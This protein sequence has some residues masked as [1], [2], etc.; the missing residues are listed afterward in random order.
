LGAQGAQYV[1]IASTGVLVSG[2]G[3][4]IV[5]ADCVILDGANSVLINNGTMLA[6]GSAVQVI[7]VDGGTTSITNTGLMSA[8]SY[9][10]WNRFGAGTLN[11]TNTGTVESE[12]QSYFG[13]NAADNVTNSG[14]MIG[15]VELGGGNDLYVGVGGTVIG[16]ILGGSGN[17]RF[18]VG[19]SNEVIDGG[20]GIDTL[21]LSGLNQKMTVNLADPSQNT[22]AGVAGDVYLGIENI[23]GTAFR[24]QLTGNGADNMLSG[25]GAH[26]VLNG[27]SG[28]DTLVGGHG[29]DTLIGG[30]GADVFV[31]DTYADRGDI[32]VDFATGEDVMLINA[33]AYGFRA[34]A[35]GA[36]NAD[37]F[38]TTANSN[39]AQDATD[40]FIFRTSDSTLWFDRDGTGNLGPVLLADLADG[41]TI[42]A[43]DIFLI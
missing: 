21:D 43:S 6:Q 1:E 13:G 23:I 20:D 14:L 17:D 31:F 22:G 35:I 8:G 38:A 19:L 25:G 10:I 4:T 33:A 11:F 27:G 15:N 30:D 32:L 40:R 26:D 2:V 39:V 41:T 9:G 3:S 28:N 5:D 34:S 16:T 42:T 12:V 18:V 7:V 29:R 24:D 36:L 37:A